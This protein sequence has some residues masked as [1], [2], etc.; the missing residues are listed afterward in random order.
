M[1]FF[2]PSSGKPKKSKK[3]CVWEQKQGNGVKFNRWTDSFFSCADHRSVFIKPT[4]PWH[5]TT[6]ELHHKG[7]IPNDDRFYISPRLPSLLGARTAPSLLQSSV[8]RLPSTHT[9][10]CHRAWLTRLPGILRN[11]F[12]CY[13]GP[14]RDHC[15]EGHRLGL[16]SVLVQHELGFFSPTF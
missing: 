3:L 5:Q 6:L 11:L 8:I 16:V 9:D 4:T 14:L 1:W 7:T 12:G 15:V 13:R 10:A 2:R